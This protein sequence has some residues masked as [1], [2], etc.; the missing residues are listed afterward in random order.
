MGLQVT[1]QTFI[2]VPKVLFCFSQRLFVIHSKVGLSRHC[3]LRPFFSPVAVTAG[4]RFDGCY[5]SSQEH[6]GTKL[7]NAFVKSCVNIAAYLHKSTQ[8]CTIL[9]LPHGPFRASDLH[10]ASRSRLF[11][12]FF[13]YSFMLWNLILF[14][15]I[16]YFFAKM[17]NKL[18]S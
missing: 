9:Q 3:I 13:P 2:G 14:N 6:A 8:V 1:N 7:K 10:V 12:S 11:L 5:T 17:K 16:L 4:M 18:R 15:F